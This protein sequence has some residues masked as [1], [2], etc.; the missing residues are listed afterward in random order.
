[1]LFAICFSTAQGQTLVAEDGSM[2]MPT[3]KDALAEGLWSTNLKLPEEYDV[4]TG[5]TYEEYLVAERETRQELEEKYPTY[6]I[7]C[8]RNIKNMY[9]Y[10]L[11]IK[12]ESARKLMLRRT[13]LETMMYS[14]N[15]NVNKVTDI[16]R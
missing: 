5:I 6:R 2:G 10:A 4:K 16:G 13:D 3:N 12:D 9:A 15:I 11:Q 1:M 8:M 7:D 14:G